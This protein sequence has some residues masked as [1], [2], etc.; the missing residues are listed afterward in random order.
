MLRTQ[1]NKGRQGADRIAEQ[2]R[3][4]LLAAVGSTGDAANEAWQRT[5]RAGNA[6]AGRREPPRWAA[7]VGLTAAGVVAGWLAAMT[8]RRAL[9]VMA[10]ES[11][12]GEEP[13]RDDEVSPS[14]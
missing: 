10:T 8:T 9:A 1:W 14:A 6:L 3:D 5:R 12:Q 7:L 4:N 13:Y 2:T 11:V